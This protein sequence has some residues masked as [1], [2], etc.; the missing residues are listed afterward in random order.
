MPSQ[1][2]SN[3]NPD[4]STFC[5]FLLL[6]STG[7][8]SLKTSK[9][10]LLSSTA[11]NFIFFLTCFVSPQWVESLPPACPRTLLARCPQMSALILTPS[12]RWMI[13]KSTHWRL[14]A[15]TCSMTRTWSLLT[16]PQRTRFASTGCNHRSRT[17]VWM[18]LLWGWW[19]LCGGTTAS[20]ISGAH[21]L[22]PRQGRAL[23]PHQPGCWCGRRT[24]MFVK[25][26]ASPPSLQSRKH[27]FNWSYCMNDVRG[28]VTTFCKW[29]I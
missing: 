16:L 18:L 21:W 22:R 19:W 29:K 24:E 3:H 8:S 20:R 5:L 25:T 26:A 1:W 2:L 10:W 15:C 7:K 12:S 6:I 11:F 28:S 17:G 4:L 14:M 13:W 27:D 9:R 23:I